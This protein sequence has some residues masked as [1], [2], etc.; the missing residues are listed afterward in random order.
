MSGQVKN[1][2]RIT[3]FLFLMSP[4]IIPLTGQTG[5]FRPIPPVGFVSEDDS[6]FVGTPA[7]MMSPS[8]SVAPFPNWY[9]HFWFTIDTMGTRI[10]VLQGKYAGMEE[11]SVIDSENGIISIYEKVDG[12]L[13]KIPFSADVEWYFTQKIKH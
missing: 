9:S 7:I 12:D 2:I 5:S 1:G 8:L 11:W 3:V 6:S 13:V 4:G 10:G